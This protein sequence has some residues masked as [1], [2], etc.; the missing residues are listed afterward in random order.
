MGVVAVIVTHNP[1]LERFRVVL[2][3]AAKQTNHVVIIDNNS[4]NRDEVEDLCVGIGNCDFVEVGFNSGVA[5]A[6]RIG[7]GYADKYRPEWLLFLDDDTVLMDGAVNKALNIVGNLPRVGAVLLGSGDGDCRIY[8][9]RYGLFSGTLIRA[10]VAV[11]VCCR[12]DFFLDQADFDMYSRVRELGYLTLVIGCRL[13]DHRLGVRRWVPLISNRHGFVDYE[14]PWRYYYI[15]RNS[16]RL[17][18][19]GRMDFAYYLKQ[20]I[21]WGV[22]IL[23]ADGLP[24]FIKPLGLGLAHAILNELGYMDKEVFTTRQKRP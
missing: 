13:I 4:R 14:P 12:D 24:A 11:R 20:L 9:A 16:T 6:L 1:S 2:G 15:V 10:D 19:E 8:E 22:K 21:D 23:L 5:H 7:V 3:S 17:L 18:I